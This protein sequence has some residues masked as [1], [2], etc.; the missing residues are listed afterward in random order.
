MAMPGFF[1]HGVAFRTEGYNRQRQGS[2]HRSAG[3]FWHLALL[4]AL[5][6]SRNMAT[7]RTRRWTETLATLVVAAALILLSYAHEVPSRPIPIVYAPDGSI[8]VLCNDNDAGNHDER[9]SQS[10][11]ACRI[12]AGAMVPPGPLPFQPTMRMAASITGPAEPVPPVACWLRLR[13]RAPPVWS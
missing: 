3:A 11:E 2:A 13:V 10:C 8:A 1:F 12:A 5:I 9:F 7:A 4:S 6:H